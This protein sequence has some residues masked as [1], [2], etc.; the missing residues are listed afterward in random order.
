MLDF[1][2]MEPYFLIFTGNHMQSLRAILTITVALFLCFASMLDAKA[3]NFVMCPALDKIRQAAPLINTAEPTDTYPKKIYAAMADKPVFRD[4]SNLYWSMG[5]NAIEADS[6]DE[7]IKI[8]QTLIPN[9][10][11]MLSEIA[12]EYH[13]VYT[14]LYL[15]ASSHIYQTVFVYSSEKPD[16][17]QMPN[18]FLRK[19]Y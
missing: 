14:C 12:H 4:S 16:A 5:I 8:A 19:P 15:L 9:I 18:Y 11:V 7:A 2:V 6:A 3:Q 17:M 13:E 10:T 1:T